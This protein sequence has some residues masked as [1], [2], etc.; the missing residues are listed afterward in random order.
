F[1]LHQEPSLAET[2]QEVDLMRK[3]NQPLLSLDKSVIKQRRER[4]G[5]RFLRRIKVK[6]GIGQEKRSGSCRARTSNKISQELRVSPFQRPRHLTKLEARLFPPPAKEA[7]QRALRRQRLGP[8]LRGGGRRGCIIAHN[9]MVSHPSSSTRSSGART[10]NAEGREDDGETTPS[11]EFETEDGFSLGGREPEMCYSCKRPSYF[12]ESPSEATCA[13][14][15]REYDK[16]TIQASR[17]PQLCAVCWADLVA[18]TELEA[19]RALLE[20][21]TD[22]TTKCLLGEASVAAQRIK[23]NSERGCVQ[24]DGTTTA[25]GPKGSAHK[26]STMADREKSMQ[27]ARNLQWIPAVSRTA[28]SS[29]GSAT[30]GKSRS[31]APPVAEV[32]VAENAVAGL[33]RG[34]TQGKS[35]KAQDASEVANS[36]L[37]PPARRTKTGGSRSTG[38]KGEQPTPAGA[39]KQRRKITDETTSDEGQIHLAPFRIASFSIDFTELFRVVFAFLVWI[40]NTFCWIGLKLARATGFGRWFEGGESDSIGLKMVKSVQALWNILSMVF[41]ELIPLPGKG[42]GGL[43]AATPALI[44]E[45]P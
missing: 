9:G 8:P 19:G 35:C 41:E 29:S 43:A 6:K 18:D 26:V 28:S 22:A 23:E 10:T 16:K 44:C 33:A 12:F 30:S 2:L 14:E 34:T 38:I 25:R 21:P 20:C 15:F 13:V 42:E 1:F 24:Q 31:Y 37:S 32:V 4:A 11:S 7:D 40:G 17:P 27:A 39:E 3:V 5:L 36:G 45:L